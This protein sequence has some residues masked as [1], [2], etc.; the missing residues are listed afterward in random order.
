MIEDGLKTPLPTVNG[1]GPSCQWLPAGPWKT[2]LG[3]LEERFPGVEI[4]TWLSR[5][6]KSLVQDEAG[7]PVNSRTPYRAGACIFYYRELESEATIPFVEHVLFRDENI[8]VAD[9]PH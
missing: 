2:I 7:L 8:L 5:M 9:K 1:V 3:F 6:D 4:A